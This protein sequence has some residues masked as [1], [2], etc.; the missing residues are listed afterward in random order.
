MSG[1]TRWPLSPGASAPLNL[2]LTNPNRFALSVGHLRVTLRQVHGPRIDRRHPCGVSDF[3]VRQASQGLEV[4][5]A[6]HG[7]TSLRRA[8]VRKALWPRVMMRNRAVN[9][10][11]C[12]AARLRLRFTATGTR[13]RR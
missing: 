6:A 13:V 7:T 10:D 1:Q 4:A 8:H 11:G 3:R 9:Q 5:L 2:H 12:K